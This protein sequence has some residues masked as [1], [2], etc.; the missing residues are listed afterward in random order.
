MALS[1]E[2]CVPCRGGIP[3]LARVEAEPLLAQ[4]PGW[5]LS[6]D[7]VWI[8][9]SFPFKDFKAA[10]AFV[11]KVGALAEGQGHHPD[12]TF[13]WGYAKVVLYTHKIHG[14]HHNDFIMAAKINQLA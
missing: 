2:T 11:N 3:A 7:A 1:Q 13:G 12:V 5:M 14:L 6:E 8:E 10:L 9:R 4:T